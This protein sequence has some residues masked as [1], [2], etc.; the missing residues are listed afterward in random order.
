MKS[1][2]EACITYFS[3]AVTRH[4]EQGNLRK[5]EFVLAYGLKEM[6]FPPGEKVGQRV[7]GWRQEQ[8]AKSSCLQ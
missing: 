5:K 2:Q 6:I 8:E 4:C 3:V 1:L 7:Q